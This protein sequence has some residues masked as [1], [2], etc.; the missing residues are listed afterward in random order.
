MDNRGRAKGSPKVGGQLKGAVQTHTYAVK[1]AVLRVFE[2]VN[3]DDTYLEN[4]AREDKKLFLSLLARLIPTEQNIQVDKTVRLDLGAAMREADER[5]KAIHL[6]YSPGTV[7]VP[8]SQEQAQRIY[9]KPDGHPVPDPAQ[10]PDLYK[11]EKQDRNKEL[12]PEYNDA[13][14]NPVNGAPERR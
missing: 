6:E 3:E 9:G 1:E 2:A 4:L 5:V 7:L 11:V 8:E 13:P 12:W 14:R 10:H